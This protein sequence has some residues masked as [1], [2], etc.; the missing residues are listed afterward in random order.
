MSFSYSGDPSKSTKDYVRFLVGDTNANSPEL[1]DAEILHV[2]N[3]EGNAL[4]AAAACATALQ[5]KYS[6]LTDES[7]GGVSKSYSQR[8]E[9]FKNLATSLRR[10]NS[11]R[12]VAPYAGGISKSEKQ[13][14]EDNT[15][16][17]E[18][19]FTKDLHENTRL[20]DLSDE[21]YNRFN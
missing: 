12:C 17:V 14:N 13:S 9:A 10:R 3:E 15:D 6:K 19:S 18:S 1:H 5:A 20:G 7:V 2:I 21:E 16:L 8:A 11:E 4:L